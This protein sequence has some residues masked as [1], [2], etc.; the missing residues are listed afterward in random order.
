MKYHRATA[1]MSVVSVVSVWAQAEIVLITSPATIGPLDTTI[2]PTAGGPPVALVNADVVVQGTT[3][4]VNGRHTIKSLLVQK[5][6]SEQAGV[7]THST[8]FSYDYSGGAG[9]DVIFGADLSAL[10]HVTVQIGSRIDLAGRGYTSGQGPG[11]GTIGMYNAA[12]AGHGGAGGTGQ[13]GVTGGDS[14]DS[15]QVPA[16]FGS[17][18][19]STIYY[20]GPG[21]SGGGVLHLTVAGSLTVDGSVIVDGVTGGTG[22]GGGSGGGL[23]ITC[24]SFTG[25]GVITANGGAGHASG[26]GG[27]GG[28]IA[29]V[30]GTS[31]FAGQIQA[32]GAAGAQYGGAGTSWVTY[33]GGRPTLTVD[34]AGHSGAM[35]P[36]DGQVTLD[37]NL[38]IKGAANFGNKSAG[39]ETSLSLDGN[40]T[41]D[42]AGILWLNDGT[43][44]ASGDATITSDAS[45]SV[46]GLGYTG[47]QGPGAG[48]STLY[49]GAGAGYGGEGG[50]AVDN[51]GCGPAYG[52]L[53][54]PVHLGSGGG[55]SSYYGSTGGAGG[56]AM[57][58]SIGGTLTVD[59][60][61][62]A[63][64][65]SGGSNTGGGSGGSLWITCDTLAGSGSITAN[66]GAGN[67]G[68]SGG[69]GG[70]IAVEYATNAFAGQIQ[71]LGR[72][73]HASGGAGTI[74]LQPENGRAT[75]IVNNSGLAG[76]MTPITG[77]MSLDADLWVQGASSFGNKTAGQGTVLTLSGD[78]W[79]E[80]GSTFWLNDGMLQTGGGLTLQ[81]GTLLTVSGLGYG[82]GSGTGA[83][84]LGLYSA[85]GGGFG[86]DGGN[87]GQGPSGGVAYGSFTEPTEL[88][89]GGGFS[90]YYGSSGGAGGGSTRLQIGGALNLGGT[91]SA[92]G[93]NG[94]T[95][96]GGG[97]G[98]S[99]WITCDTF[100]GSGTITANGGA[101]HASA[102]GGGGGRVAV[103]YGT[104]NFTGQLTAF[105]GSGHMY[106]GAGSIWLQ[107]GSGL[108]SLF[109]DNNM[110][111][112]AMTSISGPVWFDA[113]LIVRRAAKF[114]NKTPAQ[115]TT[116]GLAGSILIDS[117]AELWLND[118][119]IYAGGNMTVQTAGVVSV[120]GLGFAAA[121]GP[122][123]GGQSLY[124]GGG[125]GHGGAGGDGAQNTQGGPSYG[126][127]PIPIEWG[128]GGGNSI[129]YGSVGGRGGGSLRLRVDGTLSVAGSITA[130]GSAG[131]P[132]CG[133]GAGG[134]LW[135]ECGT[136]AGTGMISAGGGAGG[137][138]GGGGGGG[139]LALYCCDVQMLTSHLVADGGS[140][141]KAGSPGSVHFGSS[142]IL[143]S[144]QPEST[145]YEGGDDVSLVVDAAGN[146]TLSYQW[147]REN[148][149]VVDND[150]IHGAQTEQ[151]T[152]SPIDCADGGLFYC[153]VRD[154]CGAF[155][156]DP[157]MITVLAPS[158]YDHS[159]FVDTDDFTAFVIDFELGIDAADFDGTGFVDT[160]DFTAFVLAFEAGC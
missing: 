65:V 70:R 119:E 12:G 142:T 101:G 19:G 84:S 154:S 120:S 16:S 55:N 133:G 14:Y 27:A 97:S 2:V 52:S 56:G 93:T 57:R 122:G 151:L 134:S 18:G 28:R 88:G 86:G 106:G 1:L 15:L 117:G 147:Y 100:A 9:T 98:G 104:S 141:Y 159:G 114:G 66:G 78:V 31:D 36:I 58:V 111:E 33:G 71:A 107:P 127:A 73:G 48:A 64:G 155:P 149:P 80:S 131:Q 11:A 22:S 51:T 113:D 116:L 128:S 39:Q 92:N 25:S 99:I 69:G 125:G 37:A 103:E 24:G 145:T 76:A 38:A 21:G 49:C 32:K 59:G 62:L 7:V 60:S 95:G 67:S 30:A 150:R 43:L 20:G 74:W 129:Y 29:V 42:S 138:S 146:G 8:T 41:V 123:A 17:G 72:T 10:E 45:L 124:Y 108:A 152:F 46:T 91:I 143:I 40:I 157:A 61:I 115:A 126:S 156:T 23:W 3:L 87:S 4:T 121:Q 148:E 68:G 94:G 44:A 82:S 89:S 110:V 83:G 153:L 6:A 75:W 140:G 118:G 136:L 112:G 54:N 81:P 50:A 96:A 34:N 130:D 139:R 77:Q 102:G 85:G 53:V 109:I 63:D 160:D 144:L 13:S 26:G 35:T 5:N 90:S 135:I 79:V 105:G 137:S 158:D 47:G 132:R